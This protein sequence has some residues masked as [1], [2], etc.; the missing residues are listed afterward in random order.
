VIPA[1]LK[2]KLTLKQEN[3]EDLLTSCVFGR[4][5]YVPPEVGLCRFLAKANR[6]VSQ[7]I[8]GDATLFPF[9][10]L[11]SGCGSVDYSTGGKVKAK[12]WCKVG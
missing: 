3:L 5:Q 8:E 1:F 9:A 2:G 7:R 4:L 11:A 10:N 6:V 12:A